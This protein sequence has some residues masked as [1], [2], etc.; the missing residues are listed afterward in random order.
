MKRKAAL[1]MALIFF[2]GLAGCGVKTQVPAPAPE[3][4]EP[5][6]VKMD[7][8]MAQRDD[9]YELSV[10]NGEIV[11]YTQEL[12]FTVDGYLEA[13]HVM[14]G[15][16]VQEGDVLAALSEEQTLEQIADLEEE[17]DELIT[18]GEFS[19]RLDSADIEIARQELEYMHALGQF[20]YA[21]AAK[22]LE[23][24]KLELALNEAKELRGLELQK[25]QEALRAL[26]EK[27]GKNEITAPCSGRV[28]YV[29]NAGKGDAIQGYSPV[30]YLA[31]E[32]RLSLS[33]DFI[34]E[35]EVNGAER[36]YARV[37]DRELD[38][39]YV[40]YDVGEM[41]KAVLAG[42]EM[43]TRFLVEG[44]GAELSAGQFAVVMVYRFYKEDV[45]TIPINALHR[46]G[47]GQYVYVQADGVRVRRNVKTGMTTD[48][49]AEITDGLGEG[50]M[51]YVQD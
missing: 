41:V 23:I 19:D 12:Y 7:M 3:L 50:D 16:T 37:G 8:A 35:S 42:E 33:A 2:A 22:E 32:S 45:L 43:R 27:L 5:V 18:M 13:F 20:G 26:R 34:S 47:S 36:L 39:T 51:V 31:D 10:Y 49:K 38:I 17:I 40:P 25:K 44:D 21:G 29:G 4:L 11:P 48:T 15:D 24:Q 9:I 28:V 46:D 14:I 30:I 1:P 6:D